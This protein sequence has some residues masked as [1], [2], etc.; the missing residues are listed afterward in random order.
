MQL[1]NPL[2]KQLGIG[3]CGFQTWPPTDRYHLAVVFFDLCVT[4][5]G[6]G[7]SFAIFLRDAGLE[8]EAMQPWTQFKGLPG[9]GCQL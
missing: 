8:A 6:P 7:V 4:L 2:T 9:T 1:G 5:A 3:L